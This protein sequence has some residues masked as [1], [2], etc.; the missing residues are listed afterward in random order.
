MSWRVY[1]D[2][3]KRD[4]DPEFPDHSIPLVDLPHHQG[5]LMGQI[6]L[7][8]GD[9]PYHLCGDC[10]VLLVPTFKRP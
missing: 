4:L 6:E 3:C 1:C 2:N 8:L 10:L 5:T 7:R 9:R